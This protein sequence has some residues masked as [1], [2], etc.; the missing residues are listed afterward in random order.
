VRVC[1]CVNPYFLTAP[2]GLLAGCEDFFSFEREAPKL[3]FRVVVLFSATNYTISH[4][5]KEREEVYHTH[6]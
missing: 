3:F 2:V 5:Q 1:V 6:T 4:K